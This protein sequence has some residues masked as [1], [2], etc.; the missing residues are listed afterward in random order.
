M[1]F[2][3]KVLGTTQDGQPL[4]S[5]QNPWG[6]TG[7]G[8]ELNELPG[9]Y[10]GIEYHVFIIV[11]SCEINDGNYYNFYV[12]E[13]EPLSINTGFINTDISIIGSNGNNM[14]FLIQR[15]GLDSNP[16][17]KSFFNNFCFS[18]SLI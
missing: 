15:P 9:S 18:I 8:A 1:A 16:I 12:F 17:L 4:D 2:N 7:E 3:L 6:I 5:T 10:E 11:N 13:P 14:E